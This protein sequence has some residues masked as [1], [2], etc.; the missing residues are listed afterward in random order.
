M[1][2][3]VSLNKLFYSLIVPSCMY[4]KVYNQR[5]QLY[6]IIYFC[7]F[8]LILI[9]IKVKNTIFKKSGGF[10]VTLFFFIAQSLAEDFFLAVTSLL[11]GYKTRVPDYL[12][13]YG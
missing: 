9:I 2:G 13:W 10:P 4:D 7:Q 5:Q 1:Y 12:A 6:V 11:S 3:I 8:L